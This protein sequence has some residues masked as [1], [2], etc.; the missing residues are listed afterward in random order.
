MAKERAARRAQREA[1]AAARAAERAKEV[2]RAARQRSRR[3]RA[4]AALPSRRARPGQRA[5]P[6]SSGGE[7]IVL[8]LFGLAQ[9]GRLGVVAQRPAPALGLLGAQRLRAAVVLTLAFDRRGSF[10][11]APVHSIG[12]F[13]AEQRMPG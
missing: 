2:A 4:R 10:L 1:E 3:D 13:I 12:W 9:A 11:S 7:L 6:A 5:G 8:G